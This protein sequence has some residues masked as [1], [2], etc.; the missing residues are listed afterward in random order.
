[1]ASVQVRQFQHS[2][3]RL[4]YRFQ[5]FAAIELHMLVA[6]PEIPFHTT[7]G[8]GTQFW[9]DIIRFKAAE[10]VTQYG[11]LLLVI[12][13]AEVFLQFPVHF[14]S[15]FA[16]DGDAVISPPLA[17]AHHTLAMHHTFLPY[18][19]CLTASTKAITLSQGI[20]GSSI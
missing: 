6:S 8:K 2:H 3:K 5:V 17:T 20:A 7:I 10:I 9:T 16:L 15:C 1:M 14:W 18:Y 4:V 13:Q 19:A 11:E 12:L